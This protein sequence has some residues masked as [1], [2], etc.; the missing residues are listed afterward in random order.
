MKKDSRQSAGPAFGKNSIHDVL[1]NEKYSGTYV[2]NKTAAKVENRRNNHARKDESD[3]IRV[4]GGIPAIISKDIWEVVKKRMDA[5]KHKSAGNRAKQVYILSGHVFCGECGA[6]MVGNR[7]SRG[8][9]YYVCNARKNKKQCNNKNIRKEFL[10]QI[11]IGALYDNLF[12]PDIVDAG[13][14]KVY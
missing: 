6:A 12:S 9:S 4:P 14:P 1:R 2:F 7:N 13:R 5:N 10:E 3:I 11:I 8:T